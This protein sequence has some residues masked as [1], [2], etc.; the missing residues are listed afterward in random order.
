MSDRGG[1]A[2]GADRA[3]QQLNA[4]DHILLQVDRSIRRLG[5]G[6]FETL[7]LVWLQG[8]VDVALLQ[9]TLKQ[10]GNRFPTATA[11]L[12][13]RSHERAPLW[14]FQSARECP[15]EQC[16]LQSDDPQAV[17]DHAGQLLSTPRDLATADPIRFQLLHRPQGK[18]VLLIQYNH[19]LMD[20]S[21]MMRLIHFLAGHEGNAH[22][23]A[24]PAETTGDLVKTYLKRFSR[25]RRL[26]AMHATNAFVS[27]LRGGAIR[28]GQTIPGQAST[29]VQRVLTR[30]LNRSLTQALQTQVALSCGVPSL[31]MAVLAS[32][33]RAAAGLA[34]GKGNYFLTGIGVDLGLARGSLPSWHNHT[35]LIPMRIDPDEISPLEQLTRL[36]NQRMREHLVSQIDLGILGLSKLIARRPGQV[37]WATE[38][39]LRYCISF[40]YAYFGNLGDPGQPFF[41]TKVEDLFSIGPSWPPCGL[42]LLVSQFGGELTLQATFMPAC[43]SEALVQSFLNIM[44]D[45]LTS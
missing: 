11:R 36:L 22:S 23:T 20:H 41:G 3:M 17:L 29:Q 39:L 42:T 27:K 31:S 9:A 24:R 10:L 43:V 30:R 4:A 16:T 19:A 26:Q 28:L 25:R 14:K 13:E 6:G 44:L 33:F 40:W 15:L 38:L 45:D 2:A 21:D 18:D 12:V 1:I 8:R 37:Q 5:S 7:T 32:A 34:R 35:S